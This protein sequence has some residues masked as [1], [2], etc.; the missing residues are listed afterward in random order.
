MLSKYLDKY[1]DVM[2][3]LV[4]IPLINT[5]NYHLTYEHIRWD[6]YTYTTYAIDTASGFIAW[7]IIRTTILWFDKKLPY[8]K[9]PVKRIVLQIVVTNVLAQ[10]FIILQT[11]VVNALFG[12]GPLPIK[13]YTYNLFIFFIWILVINGIYVG[14]Y[15]YDSWKTAQ[16]LREKDKELR[17]TG[18]AVLLGNITKN[19]EFGQIAIMYVEDR[20]TFL[21]TKN[22]EQFVVD[23]SLN[24]IVPRLPEESFFRLNRKYIVN[25]GQIKA[26]RKEMNGKL[27]VDFD[28]GQFI[29][30]SIVSRTT[31]PE[32]K[33]WFGRTAHRI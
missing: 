13:F 7:M 31:A 11:E 17:S 32:F 4:L 10:G 21:R 9:A 28:S 8:L 27:S 1:N 14:Y 5:V 16:T 6:W 20:T 22:G 29:N 19:I 25:R 15:F 30:T 24:K 23:D 33:K 26:Y 3:F 12:D 2:L 18:F